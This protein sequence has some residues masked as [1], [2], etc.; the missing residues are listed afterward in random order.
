MLS[1]LPD[2]G[3]L[4]FLFKITKIMSIL[5]YFIKVIGVLQ[6][7]IMTLSATSLLTDIAN[8]SLTPMTLGRCLK[9]VTLLSGY[10][11]TSV[12]RSQF[13]MFMNVKICSRQSHNI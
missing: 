8:S 6:L 9:T 12:V 11:H 5:L 3:I 13:E 2:H 1:K 10:L 4:Y 7:N